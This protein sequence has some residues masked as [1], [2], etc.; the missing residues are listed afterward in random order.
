MNSEAKRM[1]TG[2]AGSESHNHKSSLLLSF[3]KE[4]SS[5]LKKRRKRLSFLCGNFTVRFRS[6]PWLHVVSL[7]SG[8]GN[9]A[10]WVIA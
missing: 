6:E 7:M 9:Y 1:S 10:P 2:G 4:E 5:F 8:V 3:K